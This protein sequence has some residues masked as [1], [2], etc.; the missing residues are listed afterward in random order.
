MLRRLSI[1]GGLSLLLAGCSYYQVSDPTTGR[2]YYTNTVNERMG[3]AVTFKDARTGDKVTLQNHEVSKITK[4][5]YDA[6][7]RTTI[8][9]VPAPI[10]VPAPVPAGTTITPGNRGVDIH[11]PPNPNAEPDDSDV[12]IPAD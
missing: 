9:V 2:T 11:V 12:K 7:K 5:Q 8:T 3:G 10:P 6:A 1:L 4:E